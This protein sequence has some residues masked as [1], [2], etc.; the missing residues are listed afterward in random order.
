MHSAQRTEHRQAAAASLKS[1]YERNLN[2]PVPANAQAQE[3]LS[4]PARPAS[5]RP[6]AHRH[7]VYDS[8]SD[9]WSWGVL[10]VELLA[11]SKPYAG[12]YATP[13]QIAIQVGGGS[14]RGQ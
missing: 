5:A 4:A 8:R 9:V 2:M 12:L 13:V 6:P 11:Q 10:C 14:E 1:A 7:E 3:A